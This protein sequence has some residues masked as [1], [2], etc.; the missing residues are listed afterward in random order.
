MRGIAP[1]FYPMALGRRKLVSVVV[2]WGNGASI[3]SRI[4]IRGLGGC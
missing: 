4:L 1:S 3:L 2:S